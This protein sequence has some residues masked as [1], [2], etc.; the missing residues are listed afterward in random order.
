M[1]GRLLL[2]FDDRHVDSWLAARPLFDEVEAEVTFFVME[3]DLLDDDERAGL[4]VLLAD[5]HTVGSHGARHRNAD[6][7][8]RDQ[9]ADEYVAIE[10]DPSIH[11]LQEIG[12]SVRSF[13]YPN[14]RRDDASDAVLL[15]RFEYL[16]GGSPRTADRAITARTIVPADAIPRVLPARGSDT[17]RGGESHPADAETMSFLLRETAERDGVLVVLAHDIAARSAFN[18][19]D[20]DRLA[21]ILREARGLGLSMHGFDRLPMP[22]GSR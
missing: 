18:H 15:S 5:G 11:A 20:P 16:R 9:G 17:G 14:T 21:V 22:E 4:Q 19:I 13:A 10:I 2:T 7:T 8:I 12:A 1:T 6:E 3:A